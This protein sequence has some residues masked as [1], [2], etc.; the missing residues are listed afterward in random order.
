MITFCFLM[1]ATSYRPF[2]TAGLNSLKYVAVCC[3][4]LQCVAVCSSVLYC[5][6]VAL[7]E[8][9]KGAVGRWCRVM[10]YVAVYCSMLQCIVVCCSMLQ[11][12]NETMS[13]RQ[14]ES[15]SSFCC[16]MLQ[17]V[18]VCCNVLQR[19]AL[20]SS[21]LQCVAMFL[22]TCSQHTF[23]RKRSDHLMP[24]SLL[25]SLPPFLRQH[26]VFSG[27]IL[28][29]FCLNQYHTSWFHPDWSFWGS[30]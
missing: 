4:M 26:S 6:V 25:L 9:K 23:L 16:S 12:V 15:P 22:R 19:V 29:A 18:A 13:W 28:H 1:I 27:S 7:Y 2:C 8:W 21:V 10:Q 14:W 24:A 5:V 11:W 3:S 17:R 20:S 30:R